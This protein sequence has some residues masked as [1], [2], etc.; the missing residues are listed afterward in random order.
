M[1]RRPVIRSTSPRGW[2][3]S[4]VA[5]AA[6][7][8][9]V[10]GCDRGPDDATL[11]VA[12]ATNFLAPAAAI[13]Q[14]FEADTQHQVTIVAGST[15]QLYAQIV[16]GAPFDVLLAADAERPALLAERGLGDPATRFTYAL[17]RL[18]LWSARADFVDDAT[19]A[20]LPALEFRRLAIANPAL[21]PYG[22]AAMQVLDGLGVSEALAPRIVQGQNIG[23]AFALV[24]S[25]NA[26]IGFIALSQALGYAG[27]A[28]YSVVPEALHEP[29]RQDAIVLAHAAENPAANDFVAFLQSDPARRIIEAS[30]YTVP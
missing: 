10:A 18:V 25:G 26:E 20:Q 5:V 14:A 22:E 29:I 27:E 30:G 2:R 21:A 12:V 7:G 9:L 3:A 19:L 24:E 28:S 13:E 1:S 17:G 15:G 6:L 23:Q 4:V 16:N 8:A 11:T